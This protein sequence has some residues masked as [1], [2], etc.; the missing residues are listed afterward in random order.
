MGIVNLQ[1]GVRMP[2]VRVRHGETVEQ[3]WR[4]FKK[5][6]EAAGILNEVKRRQSYDKPSI[7]LKKKRIAAQKRA[8]RQLYH[9]SG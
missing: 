5:Q 7:K 2:G 4:Y 6:T 1:M 8:R 3:V 9:G